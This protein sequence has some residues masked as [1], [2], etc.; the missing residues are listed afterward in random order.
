MKRIEDTILLH[1]KTG[2]W[3][4]LS[5]CRV[6]GFIVTPESEGS[7][8]GLAFGVYTKAGRHHMIHISLNLMDDYDVS[9]TR[10]ASN[11]RIVTVESGTCQGTELAEVITSMCNRDVLTAVVTITSN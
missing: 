8:G 7:Q 1:I 4:C 9:L 2:D 5:K 6:H 3:R 10:L 11:G